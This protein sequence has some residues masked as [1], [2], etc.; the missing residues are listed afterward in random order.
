ME[1][2]LLTILCLKVWVARSMVLLTTNTMHP[3]IS[4]RRRTFRMRDLRTSLA[5]IE[6][7]I[8]QESYNSVMLIGMNRSLTLLG[9]G[10]VDPLPVVPIVVPVE[11]LA[12]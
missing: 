10:G 7:V 8:V 9:V 4:R 11:L 5:R 6:A 1:I 12:D 3:C 2:R